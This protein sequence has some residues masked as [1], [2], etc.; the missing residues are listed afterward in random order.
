M[1]EAVVHIVDDDEAMRSSIA[2]LLKSSGMHSVTYESAI[3]LLA[4]VDELE[5]GCVLTDVRMP[6][7]SGLDLVR[8]LTRR[9][10]AHPIVMIT[11][12]ADVALAVEAMKAGVVDF[13]EK[14]FAE[15]VLLRAVRGALER[16]VDQV[17]R[18][19]ESEDVRLRIAQ[20][21]RRER[22]V[23]E[24]V[25][26]GHSNKEAARQ[27]GISPRTVEIYRANVMAKMQAET[28]SDL[29]RMAMQNDLPARH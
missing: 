12:H 2:F 23:F 14:P 21:T 11:G 22:E 13:I 18:A 7:M 5:P 15:D 16:V 27:L 28:L 19:R 3:A 25:S 4:R 20:L 1:T 29:V 26:Q 17:E 9:G 10:V 8:E 24:A 6:E